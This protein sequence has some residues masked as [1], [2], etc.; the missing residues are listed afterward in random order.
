MISG[1]ANSMVSIA[2]ENI[3]FSSSE[4]R[5]ELSATVQGPPWQCPIWFRTTFQKVA[6]TIDP[7]IPTVLLPA[8]RQH[9]SLQVQ[10][11]PS[12]AIL[13]AAERV[14]QLLGLLQPSWATVPITTQSTLPIALDDTQKRAVGL[15]FSGGVD[16]FYSLQKHKG[17]I[18]HLI[19]VH[20][21]DIPLHRYAMRESA[22]QSIRQ[23][24]QA[25]NLELIEVE[26][27]LRQ[28]S[29]PVIPWEEYHGAAKAAI[30]HLLAPCFQSIYIASTLPYA[31]LTHEDIGSHPG[32]DPLWSVD[33]LA[34]I[35]DGCEV[36]RF[37]K[38]AAIADWDLALNHLRVC[39]Q[40]KEGLDNCGRCRKC[41]W[42]MAYL[43]A[44]GALAK[45]PT[46]KQPL[47]LELLSRQPL[48]R[49]YQRYRFVQA[50]AAAEKRGHDPELVIA[51]RQALAR[52]YPL[53]R[54]R[55][56]TYQWVRHLKRSVLNQM[57]HP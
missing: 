51:L 6:P 35:H 9:W 12:A 5:S 7:L 42:T 33:N 57:L 19:F 31:F 16:S 56:W 39:W 25:L 4:G 23:I 43:Q 27:N 15:F 34:L 45:T 44:C 40:V 38:I 13:Q 49:L 50:I 22:A 47:D 28:F 2:I 30:A 52:K 46:F 41:L 8:M 53:R 17:K 3:C 29:D 10:G 26:T 18:T 20:G 55:H 1:H 54:L 36:S 21:F 32:I 24:A 37:D 48:D 11:K 14:Q